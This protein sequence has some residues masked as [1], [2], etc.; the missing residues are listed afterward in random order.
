MVPANRYQA[1]LKAANFTG[2]RL[3]RKTLCIKV[4]YGTGNEAEHAGRILA[5]LCLKIFSS[6]PNMVVFLLK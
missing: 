1:V 3:I 5:L 6:A 4:E 2:Y